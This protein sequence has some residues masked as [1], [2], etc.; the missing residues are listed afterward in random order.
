MHMTTNRPIF[1]QA[2]WNAPA[3][4]HTCITTSVNDFN[5]ANHVNDD[6]LKVTNNRATLEK[7]LP[8]TPFWL[9]QTHGTDVINLGTKQSSGTPNADAIYT[10]IA[11]K[12]CV[13]MTA[14]CLPIL[15]TNKTGDFVAAIHAGWRGLINGII[16]KTVLQLNINSPEQVLAFIGPA[17]CQSCFEVDN[18]VFT[19]FKEKD[20]ETCQ[21]FMSGASPDKY[22]A[23]L[24]KIA[25]LKL[26]RLGLLEKNISNRD[27]CTKCNPQWFYS[28]RANSQT[29][30]IATLIWK[31]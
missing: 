27:I 1:L 18:T 16:E 2:I 7:I 13:I 11:N 25:A 30:R 29:G 9:N 5:I 8:S 4:I 14:D 12:V 21:H 22:Q 10:N 20:L 6:P 31:D 26:V 24:R 23:D 15:L 17:I 3:N 19:E 28:Y